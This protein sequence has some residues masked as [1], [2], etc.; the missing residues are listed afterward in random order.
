[1]LLR[2][3]VQRRCL[4]NEK[5][6][7]LVKKGTWTGTNQ[8]TLEKSLNRDLLRGS[9]V[10]LPP[11]SLIF[12]GMHKTLTSVMSGPTLDSIKK[13][14]HKG[15]FMEHIYEIYIYIYIWNI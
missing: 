1:M 6:L 7:F 11:P 12:S 2:R 13:E 3:G 5:L 10:A 9:S 15:K 8:K 14:T 4:F